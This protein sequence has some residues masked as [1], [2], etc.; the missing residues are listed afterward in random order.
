VSVSSG[1]SRQIDVLGR[2]SDVHPLVYHL[3]AASPVA[4]A[5]AEDFELQPKDV[6]FVDA[7][8]LVR[9]SRVISLLLPTSQLAVDSKT[10]G[11][12]K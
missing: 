7:T 5:L 8:S 1:G 9:W 4:L 3:D 12:Y 11:I 6:V 10:I 2:S